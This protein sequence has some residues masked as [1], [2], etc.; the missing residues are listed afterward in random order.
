MEITLNFVLFKSPDFKVENGQVA[1]RNSSGGILIFSR[2][3]A[4]T[5]LK[6]KCII[7]VIVNEQKIIYS[8]HNM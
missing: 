6:F 8:F 5:Q 7:V 1:V 4:G 3:A 2:V